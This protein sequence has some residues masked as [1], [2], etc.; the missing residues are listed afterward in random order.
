MSVKF[1]VK[2]TDKYMYDFMLYHNY[3]SFS[4][5]LGAIVGVFALGWG[6]NAVRNGDMTSAGLGFMVAIMFLIATPTT[7]KSRAKMQV[8][9]TPSFR[10]PLEYELTEEGVVVRQ[11]DAETFSAWDEFTK[12]VSTNRSIL[13]YLSRVRA[14]IFPKECM[15]EQYEAA[16][17]MI[18]TH[19]PAAKVKIRHIH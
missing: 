13:L 3:S 1:N 18:S 14:I 4:G 6:I 16:V 5:L 7:M 12:V 8:K 10:E 11:G 17:K 15:G 9:N 2:M 19:V